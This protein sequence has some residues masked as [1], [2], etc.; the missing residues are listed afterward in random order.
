MNK[1]T[2]QENRFIY[3]M[4]IVVAIVLVFAAWG[5]FSGS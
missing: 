4:L 1:Q 5:Y 2:R 3:A